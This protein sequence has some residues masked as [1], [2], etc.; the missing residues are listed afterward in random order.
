MRQERGCS[1]RYFLTVFFDSPTSIASTTRPLL[2]YSWSR[3]SRID[4]SLRQYGHHVAQ[5]S[6]STTLPL[7]DAFVKV[8][9]VIVFAVNRGASSGRSE[10][11][12]AQMAMSATAMDKTVEVNLR[13]LN[14]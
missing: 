7:T 6:S 1:A 13:R 4:S 2:A 3:S 5:N 12:K 8:S 10:P 11:A 14:I 9:P